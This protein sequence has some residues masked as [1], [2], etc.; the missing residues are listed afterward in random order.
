M[1]QKIIRGLEMRYVKK[2]ECSHKCQCAQW[3]EHLLEV[4]NSINYYYLET[5]SLNL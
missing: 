3:A 2:P 5:P 1:C 4:L